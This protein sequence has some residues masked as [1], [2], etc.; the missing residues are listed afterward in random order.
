L[1]RA[2]DQFL[3]DVE[4]KKYPCLIITLP[5]RWGKTTSLKA[6]A[7]RALGLHPEWDVV[8]ATY[9]QTESDKKGRE[10][11][12]ILNTQQYQDLFNLQ[13]DPTSNAVAYVK[14]ARGGSFTATSVD[15]AITGSGFHIGIID[16]PFKSRAEAD[17]VTVRDTVW[18]WYIGTFSNRPH[19]GGGRIVLHTRW[20]VDDLI[21][22]I[23]RM[24]Q[25]V[26]GVDQFKTLHFRALALDDEYDDDGKLMRKAGEAIHPARYDEAFYA[27]QRKLS[28]RDFESLYQG[29]PYEASG[30]FFKADSIKYYTPKE[31]SDPD[32]LVSGDYSTSKRKTSDH[33]CIGAGR[34]DS[35][36]RIYIHENII[37]ERLDP[38]EAVRR[39]VT[40]AKSVGARVL[41]HEKGVIKNLL[42]GLFTQE[43]ERQSYY[44]TFE[45]AAYSRSS[46]KHVMAEALLGF[47]E[48]GKVF[49]PDTPWMRE[50]GVPLLLSF[51]PDDDHGEDDFI[52][53]L[54]GIALAV[55]SHIVTL[56]LP[57]LA[58]EEDDTD[59]ENWKYLTAPTQKKGILRF[60]GEVR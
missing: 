59:E 17:S 3:I 44:L 16:D 58:K 9:N 52:D 12:D 38:G 56:P 51:S 46:A 34:L 32:W 23:L 5:P 40:F 25:E 42:K 41:A 43:C 27:R 13:L 45:K 50:V 31:V 15:G 6:L 47:M 36:G 37:Y 48:N 18:N 8:Y 57:E 28:P 26:D 4:Q 11:R 19:P 33:T 30:T 60:N 1:C 22:R 14:T 7:A 53:M 2:L 54:V 20:H 39:T 10:V 55:E 49:F 29:S 24:Q 21:G 35:E